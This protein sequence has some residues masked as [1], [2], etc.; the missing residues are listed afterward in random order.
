MLVYVSGKYSGTPEE[1]SA[2]IQAAREASV[3]VWES[4]N[5]ALCPHLNTYHFEKDCSCGYEDYIQGDLELLQRCDAILMLPGWKDSKG[6]VREHSFACQ[7]EKIV[8]YSINDIETIDR[9]K[10]D[11]L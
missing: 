10:Y 2:N 4:G 3:K 11:N 7:C 5:T 6:A 8:Y 9:V 1:I